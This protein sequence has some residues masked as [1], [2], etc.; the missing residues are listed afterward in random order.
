MIYII[1]FLTIACQAGAAIA[2]MTDRKPMWFLADILVPP[3]GVW[4]FFYLW[5]FA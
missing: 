1:T 3:V 2:D 5:V 4:R